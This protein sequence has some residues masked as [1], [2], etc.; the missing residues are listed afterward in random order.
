MSTFSSSLADSCA[1]SSRPRGRVP[2]W[3]NSGRAHG[4]IAH[5]DGAKLGPASLKTPKIS[6]ASNS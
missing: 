3:M 6:F 5:R 4:A 1:I 2:R